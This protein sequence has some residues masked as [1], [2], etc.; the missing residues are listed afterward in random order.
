ME[1]YVASVVIHAA[2]Y[3]LDKA[4][5]YLIPPALLRTHLEGCRVLVPFGRGNRRRVG[6]IIGV[7]ELPPDGAYTLVVKARTGASTDL[8]PAVARRAVTV[9]AS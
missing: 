8:A 2:N 5:S 4:Y 6:M 9:Q 7:S 1:R 3:P